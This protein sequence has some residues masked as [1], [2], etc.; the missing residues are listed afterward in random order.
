MRRV[1]LGYR[2]GDTRTVAIPGGHYDPSVWHNSRRRRQSAFG[3]FIDWE[4]SRIVG[5]NVRALRRERAWLPDTVATPLLVTVGTV[6]R[7]E[8]GEHRFR[9]GELTVLAELFGV[10]VARLCG[11]LT[12]HRPET[13]LSVAHSLTDARN[14]RP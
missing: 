3:P 13:A 10:S 4:T 7:M 14:P 6:S 11:A 12:A 9:S 2:K 5:R 1:S 8:L